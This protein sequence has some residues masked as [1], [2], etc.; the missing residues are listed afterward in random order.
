[1]QSLSDSVWFRAIASVCILSCV[2]A[3]SVSA[4]TL[5][6]DS[7]ADD[8][9]V[10]D[11]DLAI[12][13]SAGNLVTLAGQK[14][15]LRMAIHAANRDSPIG[16]AF[17]CKAANNTAFSAGGVD[18]IVF[19]PSLGSATIT[20]DATRGM[21]IGT[22]N[23]TSVLVAT[24]TLTIDG[25]IPGSSSSRITLDG[26]L[27]Q[28]PS[29]SRRILAALPTNS[30]DLVE[31]KL[32]NINLQNSRTVGAGGCLLSFA[33]TSLLNVNFTN[34]IADNSV[35]NAAGGALFVRARDN[36]SNTLLPNVT[37]S[38]TK[39]MGNAVVA[40]SG[41]TAAG[42]GA[43]FLGSNSGALGNVS[44]SDVVVGGKLAGDANTASGSFGGGSVSR[45]RTV[46]IDRV[47]VVGNRA[48]TSDT[49][50]LRIASIGGLVT[51]NSL[52]IKDNRAGSNFGGL[53]IVSV[54]RLSIAVSEV[55]SNVAS[56][57]G[58]GGVT[59]ESV[60]DLSMNGLRV[61]DNNAFGFIGGMRVVNALA[62]VANDVAIERNSVSS[63]STGGFEISDSGSVR[64]RKWTVA[65]NAVQRGSNS[66]AGSGGGSFSNNTNVEITDSRIV[67]NTSDFHIGA[68][69]V[70]ASYMTHDQNGVPAPVLPPL[71]NRFRMQGV[72]VSDNLTTGTA[73]AS[74]GFGTI[75]LETPG[76]YE[77]VNT[78]ISGNEVVGGGGVFA[79]QAFNPIVQSNAVNVTI[80]NSTIAR[81]K[82]QY[83][84]ALGLSAYNP[85]NPS[86]PPNFNGIVAV[87]SSIIAG[88]TPASRMSN[89]TFVLDTA[90][91]F[92]SHSLF[93]GESDGSGFWCAS[94][95]N[96]CVAN[97][98]LRPIS[99]NGGAG[100]SL[101][102]SEASPAI[103]KGKNPLN[104]SFDARGD[105]YDRLAGGGVDI[106]AYER[107][108]S[109][110]RLDVDEDGRTL[111]TTD[112]LM[113][114]RYLRNLSNGL[115]AGGTTSTARVVTDASIREVLSGFGF[116]VTGAGTVSAE[117]AGVIIQR[118]LMGYSGQSLVQGL[119][120]SSSARTDVA[121]IESWL[122]RCND[123]IESEQI[124]A[125][126]EL[127]TGVKQA[128]PAEVNNFVRPA[129]DMLDAPINRGYAVGDVVI[130]D[131][132]AFKLLGSMGLTA[133]GAHERFRI[134][135][136]A[137]DELFATLELTSQDPVLK[138][139]SAL[140]VPGGVST[141]ANEKGCVIQAG[142]GLQFGRRCDFVFSSE[143]YKAVN[144]PGYFAVGI[145]RD[146]SRWDPIKNTGRG[147]IQIRLEG[148]IALQVS[149]EASP[150]APDDV[151]SSGS[152]RA[153]VK[154]VRLG[155]FS[156]PITAAAGAFM[157]KVPL[158]IAVDAKV[159][160]VGKVFSF[161]NAT[162]IV[163]E[164]G[165][166]Q[167]PRAVTQIVGP[168]SLSPADDSEKWT[169]VDSATSIGIV[170]IST[171]TSVSLALEVGVE[172]ALL[173]N[174]YLGLTAALIA[175]GSMTGKVAPALVKVATS[176]AS[177]K[178]SPQYCLELQA[179]LGWS[180]VGYS[181]F[182]GFANFIPPFK[183][184]WEIAKGE[185]VSRTWPF[186]K[187][188]IRAN[189]V[190][191]ASTFENPS[192]N[193][194]SFVIRARVQR[195]A[196]ANDRL[197]E[198]S[199]PTGTVRVSSA[200]GTLLC[201]LTLGA[202]GEGTCVASLPAPA[203]S[204]QLKL[205]FQGDEKFH[206]S[207][208]Q[209]QHNV[210]RAQFIWVNSR[211]SY[212]PTHP[213]D[214]ADAATTV[215]IASLGL[216]AGD[217]IE[218]R[219][220]GFYSNGGALDLSDN[221]GAVFNSGGGPVFPA[222]NSNVF[223]VTTA[224]PCGGFT[225]YTSEIAQDFGIPRYWVK[226]VVPP[227]ATSISFA[228][229]D[230]YFRDNSDTNNDFGIWWRRVTP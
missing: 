141:A 214:I 189:S 161:S 188:E 80:A 69:R 174:A 204:Q 171:T 50:G 39:F 192:F 205:E 124:S 98:M 83:Q 190:T 176:L 201:E 53:Q 23:T 143:F 199:V 33:S 129:I 87:T 30:T 91:T 210:E 211:G 203:Q 206:P 178:A 62:L 58:V 128:T 37:L 200:A 150:T 8:V 70:A 64:L 6:V 134:G 195:L 99:F 25:A 24:G 218:V 144:V 156:F 228:P 66:Y 119:D 117:I 86:S 170:P 163:I 169:I 175:E 146:L 109:E 138:T 173:G 51:I 116:D 158:C 20:V 55:S 84:E 102:I 16:G 147:T 220:A 107:A 187:C 52:Q 90:K 132:T 2:A 104:L 42:G 142:G 18:N 40:G 41:S 105:G 167:P 198:T 197:Y 48:T 112:G 145:S 213:T 202:N 12:T 44:L 57:G 130:V 19:A 10:R 56:N 225:N 216:A 229:T 28:S 81:N 74:G 149:G 185:L 193:E 196:A 139:P 125:Q 148:E 71:A 217:A 75:Y 108:A 79:V 45:A 115:A 92:I 172:L 168:R 183:N 106:G 208:T 164:L 73:S 194:S 186:G 38:N 54:P 222:P 182:T 11:S 223:Y 162:Q 17:G 212:L 78:T 22:S 88:A 15:T 32:Q 151:C 180:L 101:A 227:N 67:G 221:M 184:R 27:R 157:V 7:A 209:F 219:V 136:P 123:P 135:P 34:C 215:S 77:F 35:N 61:A 100:R 95:N 153:Q 65:N 4:A 26:G 166:Q 94:N 31:V 21:D 82:A 93:E 159:D 226:V 126:W 60:A 165:N 3:T 72:E 111:A 113:I 121:A 140:K 96:Q 230:C 154:R 1:M 47:G 179:S 49:G 85:G 103:D 14:C 152:P 5:V 191:T 59:F 122:R 155:E 131:R 120:L 36:L 114:V 224:S 160:L 207:L 118:F 177:M 110:C 133:N 89:V 97:A 76:I 29:V 46:Q 137:L 68:F 181:T 43:F 127:Q 9:H 63:G 13:D